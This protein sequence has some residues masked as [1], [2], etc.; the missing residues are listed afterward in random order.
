MQKIWV[1]LSAVC[2][3]LYKDREG[4]FYCE[5]I[6]GAVDPGLM[7]CL[8]NYRECA[9][10]RARSTAPPPST[11]VS[12][13]VPELGPPLPEAAVQRE[14][15]LAK[16][17]IHEKGAEEL[18][19]QVSEALESI[20]KLALELSEKWSIYEE[21]A[22][23]LIKM[24]EGVSMQGSHALRALSDVIGLY[25]KLLDNLKALLD[26]GRIS[27]KAFNELKEEIELNLSN[28]KQKRENLERN[29]KNVER[30][31]IPHIQR[32]KASEAKPEIGKLRLSLMKLEQLFK[33][34]KVSQDVYEK[35]KKE[36]E[37]RIK[38]L[39]YILGESA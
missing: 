23:S 5:A 30:L 33:E 26:G 1:N 11:A 37:E 15:E 4:R 20:E 22:R 18:E 31:V 25:E 13:T 36:L 9:Y 16:E 19:E 10:Y 3:Y 2:P 7:P 34:G 14:K 21:G 12:P 29:L 8:A 6:G 32:V 38:R 39:E 17:L 28:Y 24:W 27:E 35:M